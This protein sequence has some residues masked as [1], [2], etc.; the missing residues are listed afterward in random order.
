MCVLVYV[1]SIVKNGSL[2]FHLRNFLVYFGETVKGRNMTE[3]KC[4]PKN[5]SLLTFVEL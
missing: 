4:Q 2:I 1:N 3:A 5:A